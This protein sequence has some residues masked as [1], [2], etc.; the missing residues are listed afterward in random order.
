MSARWDSGWSTPRRYLPESQPA[1]ERAVADHAD[2]VL[3]HDG[4]DLALRAADEQRV[5]QL[6]GVR[7]DQA[8]LLGEPVRLHLLVRENVEVP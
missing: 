2:A 7:G 6:L 8:V 3:L 1:A 4:E 5:R